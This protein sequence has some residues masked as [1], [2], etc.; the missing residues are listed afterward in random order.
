MAKDNMTIAQK[1]SIST[2]ISIG[3]HPLSGRPRRAEQDARAIELGLKLAADKLDSLYAG[4]ALNTDATGVLRDYLGMGLGQIQIIDVPEYTDVTF[5]LLEHF[6]ANKPDIILT[7][8]QAEKGESSGML[9]YLLAEQLNIPIV[10]SITEIVS[11][12]KQAGHAGVLQALPRGQRRKVNVSLPFIATVDMAAPAPRQSAYGSAMRGELVVKQCNAYHKDVEH[13]Q[14]QVNGA[15]KR[16]KRL[17]IVN[18]KTAADRFKAATAKV[19]GGA[20]KVIYD[21]K[22]STQEILKMLISEGII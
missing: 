3:E 21:S 7:G 22:E 18:A 19:Q 4:P 20:G 12:D 16:P 9:P 1:I 13:S 6:S 14:W 15:Q 10:A 17:K 5:T 2:L 8:V 11:I